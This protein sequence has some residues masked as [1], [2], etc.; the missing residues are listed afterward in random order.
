MV[1]G[2]REVTDPELLAL[3]NGG[4]K[5]SNNMQEV[6]DPNILA[7]LNG[8]QPTKASSTNPSIS[9]G[10]TVA[11]QFSQGI[12]FSDELITDPLG[13]ALAKIYNMTTG[14]DDSSL[15]QLYNEARSNTKKRLATE[16]QER[17]VTSTLSQIGGSVAT[18]LAALK[19]LQA[20]NPRMASALQKYTAANPYKAAT[21]TGALSG[22]LYGAGSG[23][24]TLE[25]RSLEALKGGLIGSTLGPASTFVGRNLISPLIK[26]AV[27]SAKS[28]Q[29]ALSSL[30][31]KTNKPE[32]D[33]L[34]KTEGDFFFKTPGQR[35]QDPELQRLENDA[36]AGTLTSDAEKV[37]RDADIKQN[38][39]FISYMDKLAQGLDRDEDPNSLIE[40][41]AN[42]ISKR[43]KNA[44]KEVDNAYEIAREG[45]GTKV[46]SSDIREGL[47]K[48]IASI[49]RNNVYDV[50]QMPLAKS[51]IRRLA[52][53][54][55][56]DQD[57]PI[58]AVKLGELENWR[59]QGT[60]ALNSSKDR[61]EKKFLGEMIKSYDSFMEKTA[62][63][64]VDVGD[65]E[66]IQAFKNAVTKR[67]DYGNLFEKNKIV[68][69]IVNGNKTIDDTT[70][71]LMGTG[72][73][74]GKTEMANNLNAIIKASGEEAK[75]VQKDLAHA[76]TLKAFNKS[77]TGYEPNN[78]NM[79]RLSPAK[80]A[81][82]LENLFVHQNEFS[83]KLYG[84]EAVASAKKAIKELK[85]ISTSQ[86]G[87]RNPS[88]SGE[89][90]GRFLK[91]PGIKSIPGI[92][93]VARGI[94]AQNQHS[95]GAT[96]INGLKNS[97]PEKYNPKSS[98]WS[99]GLPIGISSVNK[100]ENQE[101]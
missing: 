99:A 89:W 98:F 28:A 95:K 62:E 87:V 83:E 88:G 66:A 8:T 18:A 29:N 19:G 58:S 77:I 92:G 48:N 14:N 21:G 61:T 91:V 5:A 78:P 51:V 13:A 96:V 17:P 85:I 31:S 6:T 67:R 36:R 39:E 55:K 42:I 32:T 70:K 25:D 64:A 53:Y 27:D 45:K 30:S 57:L 16:F 60:N 24:D 12:P 23:N 54:S 43:A 7:Q 69:E 11:D 80:L 74:K 1:N 33:L 86:A 84:K 20:F 79:P 73:I 81:S 52:K 10:R 3:L 100:E 72:S 71:S 90:L 50:S 82:E 41:V 35:T 44:K 34:S 47:W 37:I 9:F 38:R 15:S 65:A 56:L 75:N 101:K 2:M 49:R 94:E 46:Q 59:K 93:L 76:F 4:E 22:A 97:V 63:E 26:G 68:S 40:G